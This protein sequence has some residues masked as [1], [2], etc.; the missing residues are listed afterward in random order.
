MTLLWWEPCHKLQHYYS[1]FQFSN[2]YTHFYKNFLER[3]DPTLPLCNQ[4]LQ[5]LQNWLQRCQTT[6][7]LRFNLFGIDS[8]G[9]D[10]LTKHPVQAVALAR[11]TLSSSHNNYFISLGNFITN[12]FVLFKI[13]IYYTLHYKLC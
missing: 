6:E 8:G 1:Y 2:S 13:I 11:R 9:L 12:L 10:C 4:E 5:D 3:S 7:K